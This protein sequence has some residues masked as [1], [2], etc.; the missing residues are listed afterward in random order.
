[1]KLPLVAQMLRGSRK[2]SF[3]RTAFASGIA[4]L[5]ALG[6]AATISQPSYAQSTQFFCAISNGVPTTFARSRR[7]NVPMIA[8]VSDSPP[9]WTPLKR[10][11]DIAQRFQVFSDNG[12]LKYVRTGTIDG[13]AVLCAAS[14]RGG[15]CPKT[16]VL[17]TIP[18]DKDPQLVLRELL[19]L[20]ALAAGRPLQLSGSEVVSYDEGEAYVD[21]DEFLNIAPVEGESPA[22]ERN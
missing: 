18:P 12:M 16:S 19:N 2:A 10:C 7:G 1:M 21:M 3:L 13:Q 15:G 4:S 14:S 22:V 5:T 11:Q 6:T 8:W 17:L 9:P 20:R